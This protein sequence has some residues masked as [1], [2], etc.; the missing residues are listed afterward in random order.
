M[1]AIDKPTLCSDW[2]RGLLKVVGGAILVF[3]LGVWSL[4]PFMLP[5]PS[6]PDQQRHVQ[7]MN[8]LLGIT[9]V[10]NVGI[11][12]ILIHDHRILKRR[13]I[14]DQRL[15]VFGYEVLEQE[16]R[17]QLL[18]KPV[19]EAAIGSAVQ[20]VQQ[21]LLPKTEQQQQLQPE[22]VDAYSEPSMPYQPHIQTVDAKE[23]LPG[24]VPDGGNA[25][26]KLLIEKLEAAGLKQLLLAKPILFWGESGSGKSEMA[27]FIA[28]LRILL[29]NH[30]IKVADP[31]AHDNN[32]FD[33]EVLGHNYNYSEI[34]KALQGYYNRLKGDVAKPVTSINDE[35]TAWGGNCDPK[36]ID[37]FLV[38]VCKDVRKRPEFPILIAHSKILSALG[39]KKGATMRDDGMVIVHVRS[40]RNNLG[41]IVPLYKGTIDG[42]QKDDSG[43]NVT[44]HFNIDPSWMNAKW[45]LQEF[46]QLRGE[47]PKEQTTDAVVTEPDQ[48]LLDN[49]LTSEQNQ[50]LRVLVQFLEQE[51]TELSL[52][53]VIESKALNMSQFPWDESFPEQARDE[54]TAYFISLSA[55]AARGY[56]SVARDGDIVKVQLNLGDKQ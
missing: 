26:I 16:A 32:W 7:T 2:M 8:A 43:D 44:I 22:Y 20:N 35:V 29:F 23:E 37:G 53:D 54:R 40:T 51:K 45:L 30:T 50:L 18:Q 6:N 41:E 48:E 34:N 1:N 36:L 49:T 38:S 17:Q 24:L 3:D 19:I 25:K 47:Y 27:K 21:R 10:M 15:T 56:C 52:E 39:A 5:D 33:W 31:Q 42:L 28:M 11:G 9:G 4:T 13:E 12:L 46:P 14:L 55:I